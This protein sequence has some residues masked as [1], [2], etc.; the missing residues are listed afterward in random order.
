MSWRVQDFQTQ[1]GGFDDVAVLDVF[2]YLGR[3]AVDV[4]AQELTLHRDVVVEKLIGF[5]QADGTA[6]G[7]VQRTGGADVVDVRVRVNQVFER[8]ALFANH[9][10]DAF[11]LV[12]GIDDDGFAGL[13]IRDERAVALKGP[14]GK[15]FNEHG[16]IQTPRREIGN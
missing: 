16:F 2:L 13:W 6:A 7:F 11:A 12:S 3:A 8:E 4:E 14:D 5:V 15:G 9:L 10:S 1:T